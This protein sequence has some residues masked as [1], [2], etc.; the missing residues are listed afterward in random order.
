MEG[1]DQERPLLKHEAAHQKSAEGDTFGNEDGNLAKTL[2]SPRIQE[3]NI[4]VVLGAHQ[5]EEH[6]LE[7][8]SARHSEDIYIVKGLTDED[9]TLQCSKSV[10]ACVSRTRLLPRHE[11]PQHEDTRDCD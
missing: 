5:A 9:V 3:I 7:G 2:A 1:N 10:I 11:P 4:V 6:N 8:D